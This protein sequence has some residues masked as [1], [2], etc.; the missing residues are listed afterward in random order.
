MK[1]TLAILLC[2]VYL[3]PASGLWLNL[4]FCGEALTS[5]SLFAEA[6][7]CCCEQTKKE[8]DCC[9][10]KALSYEVKEYVSDAAKAGAF[11]LSADG[12]VC[13][14]QHPGYSITRTTC[15]TPAAQTYIQ[16]RP[17]PPL[18]LLNSVFRI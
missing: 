3:L 6:S 14:L 8:A 5:V 11:K 17:K 2:F 18:Y 15:F 1:K 13:T 12:A 7:D 4:H 10:N 16:A 9:R